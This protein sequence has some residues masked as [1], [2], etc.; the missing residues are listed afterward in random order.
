MSLT[1]NAMALRG[2]SGG[3]SRVI[4]RHFFAPNISTNAEETVYLDVEIQ[5]LSLLNF[6]K[7]QVMAI[8]FS[9]FNTSIRCKSFI[10]RYLGSITQKSSNMGLDLVILPLPHLSLQLWQAL[11][12]PKSRILRWII[13]ASING[14][15][16]RIENNGHYHFRCHCS[17]LSWNVEKSCSMLLLYAPIISYI[18]LV[19]PDVFRIYW[20]LLI[21]AVTVRC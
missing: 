11:S 12:A 21:L 8:F 4:F 13:H 17:V 3:T 18:C 5:D 6:S 19:S 2:R 14:T 15:F 9:K 7:G 16:R 20:K 1:K 10:W